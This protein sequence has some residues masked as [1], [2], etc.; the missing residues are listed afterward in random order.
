MARDNQSL[1]FNRIVLSK[2]AMFKS[3]GFAIDSYSSES[4]Q[5]DETFCKES[6]SPELESLLNECHGKIILRVLTEEEKSELE[7][8]KLEQSSK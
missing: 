8:Y 1:N 7:Q 3:Q 5:L 2:D 4:N 6:A